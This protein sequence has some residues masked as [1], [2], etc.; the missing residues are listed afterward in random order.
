MKVK[1]NYD[2]CLVNLANSFRQY[3]S[4]PI[5]HSTL[6][7]VDEI[8]N[9]K[10][11]ET[12]ILFLFDGMGTKVLEKNMPD[13]SYFR[14][15]QFMEIDSVYPPT[16]TAAT[17]S[18]RSGLTP[19]EH[20]FMGWNTYLSELNKTMTLFLYKEK[21]KKI[22]DQEYQEYRKTFEP[23]KS[24]VEIR[25]KT[26]YFGCEITPFDDY[27]YENVDQMFDMVYKY[28]T[29]EGKK[30]IYAYDVEP[31]SSMHH[32]G[33][34]HPHIQEIILD[35]EKRIQELVNQLEN[36]LIFIVADHGLIDVENIYLSDYSELE[37]M[38]ERI[39]SLEQRT[40]AF[41]IKEGKKEEF[42]KKFNEQLGHAFTLYS[43][44]EVMK[45]HLFG[46]GCANVNFEKAL[47]DFLAISKDKAALISDYDMA[48]KAQHAGNLDDEI[49]VSLIMIDKT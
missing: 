24:A 48:F 3:F 46:D 44:E 22:I 39:P 26:P 11:P 29:K 8:L 47:G 40:I 27:V 12:I 14:K 19:M 18:L 17:T 34:T 42:Q 2:K 30:F 5:Y 35:R 16:T 36:T 25:E 1:I 49:K 41:K 15:H 43:K 7:E 21:G 33:V 37:E 4:L 32:L 31:D 9:E 23:I 20:G 28:A 45:N 38:L 10:Q 13:D 6:K